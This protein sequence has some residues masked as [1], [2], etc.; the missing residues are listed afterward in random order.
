VTDHTNDTPDDQDRPTAI[1]FLTALVIIVVVI[2]GIFVLNR[3]EGVSEPEQIGLVVVA[4]NDALQR[5]NYLDFLANTCAAQHGTEQDILTRQRDSAAAR[6]ER[7]VDGASNVVV[8]GADGDKA[9]AQVR[10]H[11]GENDETGVT[12]DMSFVRED[13]AW[14]VCSEGP[15]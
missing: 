15:A 2:T 9:T 5:Q 13:G 3:G 8:D 6:G 12:V 11:F 14:K 4:Q 1:P 10:Y 7:Y